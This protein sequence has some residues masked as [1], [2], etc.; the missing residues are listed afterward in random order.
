ML[1]AVSITDVQK[2]GAN[3]IISIKDYAVITRGSEELGMIINKNIAEYLL[4]EGILDQ[5][6]EELYELSQKE[7][8]DT[9]RLA[10]TR[11]FNKETV[12][13]RMANYL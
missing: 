7:I 11:K 12:Q 5:V 1:K 3:A 2:K 9:V 6:C 8:V 4:D 13:F 10:R